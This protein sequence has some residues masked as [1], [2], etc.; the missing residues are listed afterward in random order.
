MSYDIDLVDESGDPVSV[1]SHQSGGAV[2]V[3]GSTRATATVTYNYSY[4]YYNEIDA[5]DGFRWL[6]G[7]RAEDTTPVLEDA[8]DTLGTEPHGDVDS[9]WIPCPGNAGKQLATLLEWAEQNADAEWRV[10]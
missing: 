7:K 6:D 9:Y 4:F 10:I 3:G 5:E 1:E 8:V 2:A